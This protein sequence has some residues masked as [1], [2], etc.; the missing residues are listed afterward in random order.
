MVKTQSKKTGLYILFSLLFVFNI[1]FAQSPLNRPVT[2]S[3]RNIPISEALVQLAQYSDT[4]IAFSHQFFKKE[5]N[6]DVHFKG[7]SL[8]D[9]LEE[10]LRTT[11]ID[12]KVLGNRVLLYKK[13]PALYTVSGYIQDKN[14][15]ERLI[16]ATVY[17]P[18]LQKGATTN[19]YGFYSLT[20]PVGNTDL[21]FSYLGYEE[22]QHTIK[23]D[24]N[25]QRNIALSSSVLLEEI[26]VTPDSGASAYFSDSDTP[27][28]ITLD[29]KMLALSP[30]LGGEVDPIRTA[31][32]M[33]G[34]HSG[35]DGLD[36]IF[37][38]GGGSSQNLMLLDGATVYVPYHLMGLFSIYNQ[39]AINSAKVYKGSFP[40]RYGGRLSS[41]F[42]IRT[43]EG[44]QY[45]WSGMA[46][47]NLI[48]TNAL[49][50][51]PLQKGKGAVLLAGRASHSGFLL[52]PFFQETYFNSN[53]EDVQAHFLDY[54]IKL[55][56]T[57]SQKDRLY[58]SY[59]RGFDFMG[60]TSIIEE[61][62]AV[63]NEEV[64]LN[65][66]NAIASLRWNH[67][68]GNKL[69]S[70]TTLT[71]SLFDY[72]YAILEQYIDDPSDEI[73]EIYF[74]DM[75]SKNK[76]LGIKLD[77]DYFHSANHHIRFGG[78][79]STQEFAPGLTRIEEDDADFEF[80]EE[81]NIDE[82]EQFQNDDVFITQE[83]HLYVESQLDLNDDWSWDMGLRG[84]TFFSEGKNYSRL[85]PRLSTSYQLVDGFTLSASMSRMVQYLHLI[86]YSTIRLPNDL[87]VPSDEDLLPEEAWQGEI[88]LEYQMNTQLQFSLS[89]YYKKLENLY[90]YDDE[91]EF[92]EED[93]KPFLIK[94]EGEAMGIEWSAHYNHENRGFFLSYA[95]SRSIRWFDEIDNGEPF[96]HAR[97][98]PHQIK[99]FAYQKWRKHFRLGLNWVFNSAGPAIEIEPLSGLD[100]E[101][102][103]EI[104]DEIVDDP[105]RLESYHRLD[106]NLEY[107]LATPKA[108]HTF[109]IGAYNLYNKANLA[110]YRLGF[111]EN[112]EIYYRPV[113][114]IPFR[115]SFSYQLKI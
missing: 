21:A 5:A 12:Y 111:D 107:Q 33:A 73:G 101:L 38:R 92:E 90:T 30:S 44:N 105:D 23:L 50:E 34:I 114:G 35:A 51:G 82:F 98:Q 70:N 65:W 72:E 80:I 20:L 27:S 76:D 97:N 42:D 52:R 91:Y 93:F 29:K 3:A 32:L 88:G 43:R 81:L 9:A 19:E 28:S 46:S 14:S 108:L 78:G 113:Y 26:V 74:I 16:S 13:A 18:S 83:G 10:I 49:I 55:N 41:I 22:Q 15:G 67:L 69:F 61:E 85:E 110:Y 56:Y 95:L 8:E 6:I 115:P 7:H 103:T 25:I 79:L 64:E 53:S 48:S 37:V 66:S 99:L 36:G 77:F 58:L 39:N 17:S 104:E 31:Q 68:W 96:P 60:G 62:D 4:D 94:G 63:E 84:S 109:K 57:L 106:I 1:G 54:N 86:T 47:A 112:E 87:W 100:E 45:N 2:F 24:E 11:S 75:R 59:Y 102:D 71:Y 89:A 40:A